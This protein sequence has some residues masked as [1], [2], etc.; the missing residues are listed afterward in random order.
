MNISWA[1]VAHIYNLSYSGGRDKEGH[2]SKPAQGN[3][4][5][6]PILKNSAQKH[7]SGVAQCEGPEFKPQYHKK[8]EYYCIC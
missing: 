8:S 5:W 6:D 2:G 4:S 1:L 7:G 3:S